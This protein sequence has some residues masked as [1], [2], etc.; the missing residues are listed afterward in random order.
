MAASLYNVHLLQ[1]KNTAKPGQTR[2][3]KFAVSHRYGNSKTTRSIYNSLL[4]LTNNLLIL[5]CQ[6]KSNF[7]KLETSHTNM[8][9]Y[10]YSNMKSMNHLMSAQNKKYLIT[11]NNNCSMTLQNIFIN[12]QYS[13][14]IK[15]KFSKKIT[16]K[17]LLLKKSMKHYIYMKFN[18]RKWYAANRQSTNRNNN[19]TLPFSNNTLSS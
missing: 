7:E 12:K 10:I 15:V 18:S 6:S 4:S 14:I 8:L 1:K 17:R 16:G 3:K 5:K 13:K 11:Y 9:H 19:K 2:I